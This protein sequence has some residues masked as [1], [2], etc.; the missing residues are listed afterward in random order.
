[1][2]D[3]QRQLLAT[4][5]QLVKSE[6]LA[7]IGRLATGIAHEVK[8]HLSSFML[9][10]MIRSRYAN[11]REIQNATELML[12]AQERIVGLVDEIRAFAS[13]TRAIAP[14]LESHDLKALV[15][16]VIRFVQCDAVVKRAKISL[17]LSEVPST[18]LDKHRIRQVLINLLRNAADAVEPG[19]GRIVVRVR[20]E[21]DRAIVEVE[22]DGHGI[23]P[24][25]AARIFDPFFTTKGDQGLGLGLDISRN[26]V[27]AHGGTLT[28]ESRPDGGTTFRMTL[29]IE[30]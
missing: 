30:A 9:A 3:G 4:Q 19:K 21:R 5:E 26:I 11:D 25:I 27:Q 17:E 14:E 13:G 12:D 16:G 2:R 6:Q 23:S 8:N 10:D 28:F 1:L 18:R 22:D 20:S 15:E 24:A 7:V 29:P